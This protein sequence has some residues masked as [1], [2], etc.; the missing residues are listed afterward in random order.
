MMKKK[1]KKQ[2]VKSEKKEVVFIT[3]ELK[4]S[5]ISNEEYDKV[6]GFVFLVIIIGIFVG[7]LFLVN[8]NLVTKDLKEDETT[9]TT[10]EVEYDSSLLTADSVFN[11]KDK[12]Y[13]VLFVDET[14][15]DEKEFAE[16]FISK[17][18]GEKTPIYKV[19]LGD[20][21]NKKYYDKNGTENIKPT[22]KDDL[23]LTRTT[24]IKFKKNKVVSFITDKNEIGKE[25]TPEEK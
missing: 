20:L 12:N 25:L 22:S 21:I 16:E 23:L 7:I 5:K 17:F 11:V 15:N 13:Y 2:E 18:K 9:T 3:K 19:N 24:L 14:I 1:D 4:Q 8:G 10:T 6:K